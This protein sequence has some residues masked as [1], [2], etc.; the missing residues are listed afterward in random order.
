MLHRVKRE[1]YLEARRWWKA[2]E[3]SVR[4]RVR[5][6]RDCKASRLVQSY[7]PLLDGTALQVI[8]EHHLPY[9]KS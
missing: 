6:A 1:I 2:G 8:G 4:R 9:G 7:Q 3:V 5:A